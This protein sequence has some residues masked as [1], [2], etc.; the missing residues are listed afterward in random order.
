VHD[1]PEAREEDDAAEGAQHRT[2]ERGARAVGARIP[3]LPDRA[4]PRARVAGR[5]R[6]ARRPEGRRSRRATRSRRRPIPRAARGGRSHRPAVL[7][8]HPYLYLAF[9]AKPLRLEDHVDA[10]RSNGESGRH[11]GRRGRKHRQCSAHQSQSGHFPASSHRRHGVGMPQHQHVA[12][13][14]ASLSSSRAVIAPGVS[15]STR[16]GNCVANGELPQ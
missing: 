12:V 4:H 7:R 3:A 11:H 5:A 1:R 9:G 2:H 8:E 14:G 16:R 13:S 15:R 6:G 10:V